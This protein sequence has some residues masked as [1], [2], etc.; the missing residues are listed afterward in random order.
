MALVDQLSSRNLNRDVITVTPGGPIPDVKVKPF[1]ELGV[2]GLLRT[3]GS[4]GYVY[5]ELN[6]VKVFVHDRA[7]RI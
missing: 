5:E 1:D 2:T 7:F 3:K 4:A 6:P